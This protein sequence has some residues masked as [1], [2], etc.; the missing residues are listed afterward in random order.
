MARM[1]I[2]TASYPDVSPSRWKFAR[3]GRREGENGRGFSSLLSPSHGPLR[4]VNSHSL[5]RALS[6][7]AKNEASEEEVIIFIFLLFS[8]FLSLFQ[9]CI[10]RGPQGPWQHHTE[11]WMNELS[12]HDNGHVLD[13]E[14]NAN[15]VTN[16]F[17][18][19]ETLCGK[20]NFHYPNLV[21]FC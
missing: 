2:F 4:F 5:F 17:I 1:V 10:Y 19:S 14:R 11:A 7:Y 9:F 8:F 6:L 3:K 16:F 12:H 13:R 15:S 18:S 21:A 20:S